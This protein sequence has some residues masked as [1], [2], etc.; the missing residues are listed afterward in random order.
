MVLKMQIPQLTSTTKHLL[1]C[2]L[3]IVFIIAFVYHLAWPSEEIAAGQHEFDPVERY[4]SFFT[5][6]L[7]MF[8][9][10]ALL[11]LPQVCFNFIG[12]TMYNAFPDAVKLKSPASTAPFVC[13]RTVTRGDFPDLVC[14][15]VDRNMRTCLSVGLENFLIEILTD[16]PIIGLQPHHRI[17]EVVIPADY[18]TSTGALFKARALQYALE[19]EVNMLGDKDW[20]VHLDEETILTEDVVRGIVNFVSRGKHEFGQGLITYANEEIVN[21][22]TTL[23]DSFRVSDDMGKI[24]LQFKLFHRPLFAWKG[25]FVVTKYTAEK[26]VSYDHGLDGSVA[27]DCYFSMIAYAKG[28]TFD[29]IDGTMWE[30]S[31]FTIRDFIQQRKRWLQGIFLVVHSAKIPLN[32]KIFLAVSL[33]AWMSVPLSTSNV[34]LTSMFPLPTTSHVVFNFAFAFVAAVNIYMYIFGVLKSF[35]PHRMGMIR[36]CVCVAGALLT[37]PFNVIIENIAV[38]WGIAGEK[39]KF[40]V[41]D[42]RIDRD[43]RMTVTTTTATS[44]DMDK[45]DPDRRPLLPVSV[46]DIV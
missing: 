44:H 7:Y 21:W 18:V 3:L 46:A 33:Y 41:V 43:K 5:F 4:G 23:A 10:M 22:I 29:F 26:D 6:I 14:N 15:N 12:W 24:R 1:H 27:E 40:Y 19:D 45:G 2:C 25:S 42:K 38:I 30:K 20:I 32:N 16:K 8:R 17:R 9:F 11:S 13:I 36:F 34:F 37:I 35:S 31:P 39:H 28:Y